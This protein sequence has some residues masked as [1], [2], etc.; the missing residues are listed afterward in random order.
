MDTML[1]GCKGM[2]YKTVEERMYVCPECNYHFR[3]FNGDRLK[4]LIDENSFEE[5]WGNMVPCDPL[6]F[7][8][9]I[10]Y[11]ERG[12]RRTAKNRFKRGCNRWRGG[13]INGKEVMI[14]I[15]DSSFIM[16]SMGSVVGEKITR[17]AEKATGTT[18]AVNHHF[19]FRWRRPH[20]GRRLFPD[21]NGKDKRSYRAVSGSRRFIYIGT[22]RPISGWSHGKLCFSCRYYDKLSQKR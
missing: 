15:T 16:G 1:D 14:G 20:A 18:L 4:L 13:K 5:V 10:T 12:S 8:D 19:W 17:L 21:A 3:V 11:P 2:V 7:K 6:N 9:R 22:D